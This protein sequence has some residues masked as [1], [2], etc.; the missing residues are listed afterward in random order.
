MTFEEWVEGYFDKAGPTKNTLAHMLLAWNAAIEASAVR[1]H[2]GQHG[3]LMRFDPCTGEP[4]P[5]PSQA[6][7][8]RQFHGAVAWI[9][10]PWT[11]EARDLRDVGSDVLGHLIVPSYQ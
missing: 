2:D 4:H 6:V 1:K 3:A 8:Y 10:N 7:D 9:Y 11:G 5:Y